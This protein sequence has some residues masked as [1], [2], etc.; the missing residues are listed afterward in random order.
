M[1][2]S[3]SKGVS[4]EEQ[5]LQQA[6]DSLRQVNAEIR[7][8]Y[9]EMIGFITEIDAD[10]QT[11][12]SAE[13]FVIEQSADT[14]D[15]SVSAQSRIK[16]DIEL[17]SNTLQRNRERIAELEQKLRNSNANSAALRKSIE[18]LKA[19]IAEKDALIVE[20][21]ESLAA[22][23]VRINELDQ[24]VS[25]LSTQVTD[26]TN[27]AQNQASVIATQDVA[28]NEVYYI[29]AYTEQLRENNIFTGGGL[30]SKTQ[31]LKDNFNRDAFTKADMRKLSSIFLE[32]K[33]V[34]VCTNH[35]ADS[36]ELVQDAEGFYTLNILNADNFWSLTRYLVV[37]LK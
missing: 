13:N 11:I 10:M 36:Y 35:P 16:K 24:A 21:Q 34:K 28:L 2:V 31:V 3:C 17:M 4:A 33:K 12:K 22:R 37:E 29:Y 14:G 32:S 15:I 9:E 5:A 7:N 18:L 27:V 25:N 8:Y 26:L 23:D 6:N 19:Q 30:F 1:V 20:L